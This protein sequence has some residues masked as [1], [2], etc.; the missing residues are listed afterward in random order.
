MGKQAGR[1]G[2]GWRKNLGEGAYP[3]PKLVVSL[4]TVVCD[5][6]EDCDASC[7]P[8]LHRLV[9]TTSQ[10]PQSVILIIIIS[11]ITLLILVQVQRLTTAAPDSL[12]T[13]MS[14]A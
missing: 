6:A 11:V 14:P 13:A 10:T 9:V 5:G 8:C 12:T 2:K 3:Q 1:K 7:Q 4:L